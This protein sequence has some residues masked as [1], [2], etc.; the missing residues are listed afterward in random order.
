MARPRQLEVI[1]LDGVVHDHLPV[2]W[3]DHVLLLDQ[4]HGV[5]VWKHPT[6][7][8]IGTGEQ[9]PQRRRGRVEVEVNEPAQLFG[10]DLWN[11]ELL[12]LEVLHLLA[13]GGAAQAAIHLVAPRVIGTTHHATG[14]AAT[15]L[16]QAIAAMLANVVERMDLPLTVFC[17]HHALVEQIRHHVLTRLGELADV[18][19]HMP[20]VHENVVALGLEQGLVEEVTR[21]QGEGFFRVLMVP[22]VDGALLLAGL[23][24]LHG[25]IST[26]TGRT[27]RQLVLGVNL[28]RWER[29]GLMECDQL[30]GESIKS[31]AAVHWIM[32]A[33]STQNGNRHAPTEK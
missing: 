14:G 21:G 18:P 6:H 7:F 1:T 12:Q 9:V 10:A 19:G 25:A 31:W 30:A 16:E 2:G 26:V 27:A 29:A 8:L 33:T 5:E 23:E 11:V 20:G 17:D 22:T 15:I 3:H 24:A 32:S 4:T 28:G 13:T